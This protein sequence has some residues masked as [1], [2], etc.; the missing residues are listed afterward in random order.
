MNAKELNERLRLHLMWL[1][2][3]SGGKRANFC[4]KNLSNTDLAGANLTAADIRIANLQ[5]AN[6]RKANLSETDLRGTDLRGANLCKADLSLADLSGAD[7]EGT[8][9]DGTTFVGTDLRGADFTNAKLPQGCAFYNDLPRHNI[10]VIHG[11][12]Y[13]GC[14]LRSLSEWLE[15]GAEIGS[16]NDY[17][18]EQI[19]IYIEILRREHEERRTE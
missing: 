4:R 2:N 13:I 6:L 15:Q 14:Y 9:L 11:V 1:N 7:L 10:T 8:N 16:A 12:A 3:E 19:A 5:V 18:P 17:T